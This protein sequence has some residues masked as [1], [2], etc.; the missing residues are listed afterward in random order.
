MYR[1]F[2]DFFFLLPQSTGQLLPILTRSEILFVS[3]HSLVPMCVI[4]YVHF[5]TGLADLSW[6]NRWLDEPWQGSKGLQQLTH[7][8]HLETRLSPLWLA[9]WTVSWNENDVIQCVCVESQE[10]TWI[11]SPSV[12]PNVL[13]NNQY[14]C[15]ENVFRAWRAYVV[16]NKL[17]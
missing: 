3:P 9:H 4:S 10:L 7:R 5:L 6:W 2:I 13:R 17:K 11:S 12:D 8:G 15:S 16:K 1:E 14:S